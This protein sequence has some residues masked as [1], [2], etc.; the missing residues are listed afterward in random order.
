MQTTTNGQQEEAHQG[1]VQVY[2]GSGKGKTTAAL[3]L[4][5]RA[6][7]HGFRVYFIAFM[8]GQ[9]KYGELE[10]V[11]R[12][13]NFTIRMFGRPEFVDR[14]N[15][16]PRD[17]QLAEEAL[18]HAR[19]IMSTGA[20]DFLILDEVNCAID[21]GL[22]SEEAVIDLIKQRPPQM[23]LILTGRYARP[24]VIKLADLVSKIIEV[25]HPYQKGIIARR[26]VEY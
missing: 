19:E 6:V 4:G 1:M 26:G 23:E 14:R 24:A 5:L 21:W 8:K 11:R 17:I 18:Q 3:G 16:D 25:K 13:P 20:A 9:I 2:T 7:G 22:I 10:A 15:P 12:L